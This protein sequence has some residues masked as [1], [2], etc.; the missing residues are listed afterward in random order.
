VTLGYL[1]KTDPAIRNAVSITA[2]VGDAT[3]VNYVEAQ[4]ELALYF[5]PI[6][7][8]AVQG[9]ERL[10]SNFYVEA[11]MLNSARYANVFSTTTRFVW[12][13]LFVQRHK[14]IESDDATRFK[15]NIYF[16]YRVGFALDIV[17]I[18]L[19]PLFLICAC[20]MFRQASQA[21]TDAGGV[22]LS[23]ASA[24]SSSA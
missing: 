4:H 22:T 5:E 8:Q 1:G 19:C 23:T 6:T 13:Y 20:V 11:A 9:L 10:Q 2:A 12:P 3:E 21:S 18:V 14:K 16:A 17:G 7:G 24:P 15:D